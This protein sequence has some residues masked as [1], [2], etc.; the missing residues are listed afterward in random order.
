VVDEVARS[1]L[2]G[3]GGGG[4]PTG[5]KWQICSNAPG[6]PK[7]IICNGDEGDPGAYM[8]RT[9]LESD[10][11]SVIEGLIIGGY[12]I[13]ARQGYIYV[14]DEYPLAVERVTYA[15]TQ[16]EERGL[17]GEDILG[18]GFDFTLQVVRGAG[19]FV[20]GEETALIASI[21][22]GLG[23]PRPKP[24]YPATSGL[25]GQPTVINNVKTLATVPL[26]IS[27]GADWY[28]GIGTEENA[29]TV[30]FSL[31][32][33]VA[34]TGLVEV[35]L[36]MELGALVEDIGGGGLDGRQVKAVQTGGPSGGCLPRA[37]YNL[38]ITYER[39]AQAG[40]IMGSGGMVV[41]DEET[42]MVDV[43]RYFLGFTMA[44]S[45]GKC[46]FCREGTRH[47]HDILTRIVEGEGKL[48]DLELLEEV[49]RG[50]KAASLC[51]LGQTAPNPVL[52]TLR[53][54]RDEFIAHIVEKRCPAGA[55][56]PLVRARCANACPAEVDVPSW[57]ALVAQG[58]YAEA[59]EIHRRANPFVLVCG[60]V[61]PAFCE[62]HCRRS[63]VDES[64]AIRQV[65][66]FMADHEMEHPWTPPRLEE[67][68]AER[69]AVV[70]SGP[71]G[72]TTALRLAQKGYPVTIFEKLPVLGGMLAT[73]IPAYRLPR[74]LLNF[75]IEGI[76]RAG[77]E[78]KT[79][80]A[81]GRDFTVDSLFAE[82]YQAVILAI[83]A[84]KSRPLGIEGEEMQGVYPGVD[85]LRHVAL[86][87]PP[88]LTDKVVGVVGGGDVAIDAARSAWRLG[89]REVHLI[90]RRE[91][92]QMPAYK[93][94]I[95]AAEA[96]EVVFHFLTTPTRVIGDGQVEGMECRRQTLGEFDRSGRR[97]PI[98][99]VGSEF[100]LALDVLISAI[101]QETDLEGEDGFEV[102]PDS[103]LVVNEALAT[104]RKGV[105]AAGDAVTGPA[106]VIHAVAQGN[107]VAR[108]V[109][110]YL[111]TGRT[112]RLVTLP[113]YD[114]VEQKFNPED[115]AEA[116]RPPTPV[117]SIQQRRG[118]FAEVEQRLE[119]H[120]VQ[121]DCKRCL[122]CDLEWL[123]EMQLP[124]E[125][126]PERLV[127]SIGTER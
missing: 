124:P 52:S 96:E 118:N 15:V 69:V 70:G 122:R 5:R 37:L 29:G 107:K 90:Y 33:K 106:T 38:P 4:F 71:A 18:S 25:W 55:C 80:M 23:E 48:E 24:P 72:L 17:L 95:E 20:C 100:T 123:E 13:G 44:E 19:A 127:G 91:R 125:P 73:G 63:E 76:L 57:L 75:E 116:K 65:K 113:G 64:V 1:G 119:E 46:T 2:R 104:N 79:G 39:M 89:V 21:E 81:L 6:E 16:A 42:C 58:R 111:R 92:E 97:R 115:Y 41:L 108:E 112:E 117:L 83:G 34:N 32:G 36:G 35:P 8:D 66:R 84:H 53:Y 94:Q 93:E 68:K 99:A 51:G 30:V 45:C 121:E 67:P 74:E 82:G 3:R 22:G 49:A 78:A 105:F 109:D 120:A 126:Q 103:T 86:G 50:V 14:R 12:A 114:V 43:A 87:S 61:C 27:R 10:P 98:P 7:Y 31:V 26:I 56:K 9:V 85:F 28:T 77:I 11:H 47:L 60:R 102:N 40:S 101:G 59:I 110:Y 88:D 62:E 54:F